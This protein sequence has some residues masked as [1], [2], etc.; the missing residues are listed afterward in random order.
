M[1]HNT[2]SSYR[3]DQTVDCRLRNVVPHLLNGCERF[4]DIGENWNTLPY[5]SI[6]SIP[7]VLNRGQDLVK[8]SL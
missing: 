8:V 5:K 2:S 6:Q 1:Q 4:L 3:V 7:N